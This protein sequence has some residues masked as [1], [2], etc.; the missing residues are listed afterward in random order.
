M[1]LPT[2]KRNNKYFWLYLVLGVVLVLFSIILIPL[3]KNVEWAPWRF[4]SETIVNLIV[5]VFL[6]LYLFGFL[7]KKV[8]RTKGQ[9]LKILTIIE[10][11]ILALIDLYLILGQFIPE[12][13]IIPINGGAC[14]VTGLALWVRGI[15]EIF[16]AYFYRNNTS[17]DYPIWWLCIAIG[18]VSIG[19]WM[20]VKP[21]ISNV[22]ITWI[23]AVVFFV[24][25]L[26][27]FAYGIYAK[28]KS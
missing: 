2:L 16:R 23:F 8:T 10:F 3:W 21:F 5:A 13:N 28:R 11:I 20:L 1:K 25:G 26:A 18:F 6:S 24:I 7:L 15:V 12:L 19:M 14:A 27:S 22:A 17:E 4:W 9:T